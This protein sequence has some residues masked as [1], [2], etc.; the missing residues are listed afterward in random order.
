ML[1]NIAEIGVDVMYR[2]SITSNNNA[3][4]INRC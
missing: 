4:L 3:L 2:R 1:S